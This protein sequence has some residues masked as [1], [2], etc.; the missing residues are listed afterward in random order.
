[1]NFPKYPKDITDR[2]WSK[3]HHWDMDEMM[4]RVKEKEVFDDQLRET[5]I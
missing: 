2:D 5:D 3:D 1:V 4:R